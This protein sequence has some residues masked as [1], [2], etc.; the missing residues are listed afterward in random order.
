MAV[1]TEACIS[2]LLANRR[3]E[4]EGHLL[5]GTVAGWS[6][7]VVDLGLTSW[8]TVGFLLTV[9]VLAFVGL[10]LLSQAA[11]ARP[12]TKISNDKVLI[13]EASSG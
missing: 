10:V 8:S 7:P 4:I 6:P 3:Y 13:V 12:A 1:A 2:V 9:S 11:S 5:G